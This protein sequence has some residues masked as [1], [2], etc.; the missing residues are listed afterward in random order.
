M[1]QF[2]PAQQEAIDHRG[3]HLQIIACAG[4]GKT[5]VTVE[6]INRL[7]EEGVNPEEILA[8]T[9]TEKAAAELSNRIR[10]S[11]IERELD[12]TGL[13]EMYIG[14][15]HG[16]CLEF[17][18]SNMNQ[19]LK[20]RVLN[21]PQTR[22]FIQRNS[23]RSGLTLNHYL[24]GVALK[25]NKY[26]VRNYQTALNV[27]REDDVV[28][29]EVPD[30]LEQGLA[31]Y[32]ALL[33]EHAL[34]DYTEMLCRVVEG[35]EEPTGEWIEAKR[36]LLGTLKHVLVDEYQDVNP[37]QERLIQVLQSEGA[38]LTVVGDDDQT[39]YQFRGSDAGN[40]LG[41]TSRYPTAKTVN[42]TT[43]FRSTREIVE[44]AEAVASLNSHRLV[45]R[46]DV[47]SHHF[48]D[49]GDVMALTFDDP[50]EEARYIAQR[51]EDMVGHP[52]LDKIDA[53][54]RGLAYSD[55]AVLLRS[56]KH[57]AGPIMDALRE[58]EIPF[59]V[60]GVQQLFERPEI[61]AMSLTFHYMAE[62]AARPAVEAAWA[63]AGLGLDDET[64][65][66]AI[67]SLPE[68][69]D[70][71]SWALFNLQQVFLNLIE[72]LGLTEDTIPDPRHNAHGSVV[73]HNLGMFSQLI[74]DFEQIHFKTPPTSLY[75]N[76]SYWLQNEAPD[77]YDEGGLEG[78]NHVPNAVMITTIHQSKGLQWPAVF[79][80]CL[81]RN[82]FP[83]RKPGGRTVW[84]L[85]PECAV[86]DHE[87]YTSS[88]EDERRLFYVAIT[89]A[90]R[91]L[92]CSWAPG[93]K[94][95]TTTASQFM[96]EVL[97]GRH[98]LTLE[99]NRTFPAPLPPV[100]RIQ[101]PV[102][103]LSFSEYKYWSECA[104]LF[105]LRFDYGFN[106]PVDK[107][108]GYGKSIHDA[109]AEAHRRAIMG[110]NLTVD[111]IPSLMHH[112]HFPFAHSALETTLTEA[113]R[114]AV[115]RYF[116]TYGRNL[117]DAVHSEQKVEFSPFP[118]LIVSG[119]I[120]LVTDTGSN[121]VR[122]IDF[123]SSDRAQ[124]EN[125]TME[126][127]N[128]YAAGYRDLTGDLPNYIEVINLDPGG[129][130]HRALV[131]EKVVES[132]LQKLEQASAA[133]R[134]ADFQRLE[135]GCASCGTC[136]LRGICGR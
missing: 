75:T 3:S 55:F 92:T 114:K 118:G 107:S 101:E 81:Q 96:Q 123:K 22:L 82:R 79:V 125:V 121:T 112:M 134:A 127:L 47:G 31:A 117:T 115:E 91:F 104:Y 85:L 36:T 2:T 45:K 97:I 84:H 19:F 108:L 51:I 116:T 98:A 136:D 42:V 25:R 41:F 38:C 32:R 40:I 122:L 18:Q 39:I 33:D 73:F 109:L 128:I 12:T 132:T 106:P 6:R 74:T 7:L 56:V 1:M 60:K 130:A 86:P 78:A 4:S 76:F 126:Q 129:A 71:Q 30:A 46:F 67:R 49:P 111:D 17:L 68:L 50:I 20:Y 119:R 16:W 88:E 59:V 29:S 5:Q 99:P 24:T 70:N 27:L 57:S 69:D 103:R 26:D 43:N 53:E 8:F 66:N 124:S 113:A 15:I 52:Y 64:I 62:R 35:L 77:L 10:T 87:R 11:R 95:G 23:R 37:I 44:T 34:F 48:H 133:I 21:D 63:D 102:V 72:S 54:H 28:W 100:P 120:D 131:D 9:F 14:T 93:E 13:A 94:R 89:R 80:P 105:K 83:A 65:T 90:E 135:L 61:R 110:E 58:L